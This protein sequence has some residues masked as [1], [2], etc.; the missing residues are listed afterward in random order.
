[1][2]AVIPASWKLPDSI[3]SRIGEEAGRQRTMA[4]E[5]H[6]LLILHKVPQAGNPDRVSVLFWRDP[7]GQW[8]SSAGSAAGLAELQAFFDEYSA[9]IDKLEELFARA[10]SSD[11]YFQVLQQ[12]APVLRSVRNMHGAL[13]Q[14]REAMPKDRHIITARDRA[15]EL[16]RAV[17]LLHTDSKNGLEYMIAR[18]A[19]E[20]ARNSERL[21]SAQH[22][23]NMLIA[24]FLPLTALGSAFGMN[25]RHGMEGITSPLLFWSILA[26]GIVVGVVVQS[27]IQRNSRSKQ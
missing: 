25:F 11:V 19:E 1:M 20:E 15:G 27:A 16:E 26:L 10:S 14:A 9:H 3:T 8:R 12:S 7:T 2:S 5:G 13:Q 21:L 4:A 24:L 22:R 17:E 6:L 18:R 23:L